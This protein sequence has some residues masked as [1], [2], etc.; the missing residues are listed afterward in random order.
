MPVVICILINGLRDL[1]LPA[2]S[3]SYNFSLFQILRDIRQGL[4]QIGREGMGPAM[5]GGEY[6]NSISTNMYNYLG[7]FENVITVFIERE[8]VECETVWHER[9]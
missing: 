3:I 1:C 2:H 7:S 6:R 5:P 4:L 9:A 8:K